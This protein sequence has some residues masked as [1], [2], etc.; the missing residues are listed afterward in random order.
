MTEFLLE[1]G[2]V[3]Q[4]HN[5]GHE[6]TEYL[7]K[8]RIRLSIGGEEFDVEVGDTISLGDDATPYRIVGTV[9]KPEELHRGIGIVAPGTLQTTQDAH[10]VGLF[11]DFD[12][13]AW[14]FIWIEVP[15]GDRR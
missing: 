10:R 1:G 14:T 7:V 2:S 9:V 6:Q 15:V 3:L 13:E 4:G 11:I 5:H 12:A 8:G